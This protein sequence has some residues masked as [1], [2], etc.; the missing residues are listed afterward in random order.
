MDKEITQLEN[1]SIW[2][3]TELPADCKP[4]KYKWVLNVKQDHTGAITR[5]KGCL[6]AKGFSQIPGI[7]F[8]E[9]FVPVVQL[10]TFWTLIAIAVYYK[11]DIHTMD[12]VEA[13]L[14][15][16]L[17]K[18][19]YMEQLPGYEDGTNHIYRLCHPLYGLKQSGVI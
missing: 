9:T 3:L 7:N 6:V 1:T 10:E 5:Y 17:N 2:E 15:G 16:E 13:Y 11:L 8:T 19:I 12:V 18:M 14:D 4:I